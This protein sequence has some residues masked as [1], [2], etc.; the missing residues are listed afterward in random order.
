VHGAWLE[1]TTMPSHLKDLVR[2]RREK[3]GERHAQALRH[4]RAQETRA[5]SV[6]YAKSAARARS[7]ADTAFTLSAVR[8]AEAS[9]PSAERLF[10][11]PYA[12]FFT[13]TDPEV[14]ESTKRLLDLPFTREGVRLRTRFIDDAVGEGLAAGLDQLVLLGVGFDARGLRLPAVAARSVHVFEIDTP[15][16][17]Q[18]KRRV[19]RGAGVSISRRIAYVPFDYNAADYEHDLLAALEAKGFRK[20]AGCVFVWEGVIGYVDAAAADASLAFMA[21]AGGP[22]SRVVFTYGEDSFYPDTALTRTRRLGYRDCQEYGGDALW[23]RYLPGE[24]HP[25]A[26]VMKVGVATV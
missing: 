17:L 18:R 19:L 4:L 25:N 11:D 24:P 16:Q 7:V 10:D 3:T 26:Y 9:Y 14:V 23:R 12:A 15:A 5:T 22:G 6:P 8:A 2:A 21:A 1:M 13:P 20:R